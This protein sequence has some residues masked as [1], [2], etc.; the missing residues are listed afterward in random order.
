[1]PRPTQLSG[2]RRIPLRLRPATVDHRMTTTQVQIR[3][4]IRRALMWG[5]LLAGLW[6]VV[7]LIRPMSTFHLAPFLIAGAPP[8]LFG[9][10]APDRS[11]RTLVMRI[12]A[13]ALVLA[14][15]TSGVVAAIGAMQGPSFEAFPS[16]LVEA[17]VFS[18]IGSV[19][20]VGFALWKAR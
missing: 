3:P 8:V 6:V 19:A 13:A 10:D 2:F 18:A 11:D 14:V 1:M 7:A 20:G 17:A 12:G 5:A 15:A 16:P 4:D 9:L